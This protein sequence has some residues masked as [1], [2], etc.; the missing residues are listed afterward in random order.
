MK[1]IRFEKVTLL[2]FCGID[3][4]EIE[5]YHN[6]TTICGRNGIGKSTIFNAIYYVLFG[7]DQFGNALDIKT[8]DYNHQIIREIPHEASLTISV[9][10]EETTFKRTLTDLWK[11]EQVKNTYKYFID[12][13]VVTAGDYR[14]AIENI[15]PEKTF[16]LCSSATAFTSMSWQEQRKFLQS[17]VPE[18]TQDDITQGD[19]KYDFITEELKKR[20]LDAF[21]HHLKYTRKEVQD[22]LDKVPVR[23]AELNNALP[24]AEDWE[25]LAAELDEAKKGLKEVS[26]KI[27]L[28]QNGA[29]DSVRNEGLRRRIE[30][31]QKRIDEMTTSARNLSNEEATKHESDL[32]SARAAASTATRMVDELKQKM[33]GLTNTEIQ[34]NKHKE[35][36]EAEVS[37]LNERSASISQMKWEWNDN[38][39][40]CP[41]CGQPLPL[42]RVS[43]LK[44]QSHDRFNNDISDRQKEL[45]KEF[46]DLQQRYTD[47]KKLIENTN[48]ERRNTTNQLTEAQKAKKQADAHLEAIL[49]E[50]V[51]TAD[52]FLAANDNYRQATEE[53]KSLTEELNKPSDSTKDISQL[54]I[55]LKNQQTEKQQTVDSFSSRLAAKETYDHIYTLISNAQ[56][57][58]AKYQEQLDNIDQKLDTAND[59]QQ[60]ACQLL[61]ERVNKHFSYVQFSLFK[62]T[63]EGERKQAC[64]CYHDGVP[65]SSLNTAAK[66]NAGIDIA[67]TVAEKFG[68]SVPIIL[69][70]CESNLSPIYRGGQ[71]I[72]LCVTPSTNFEYVFS[73]GD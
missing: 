5:F 64:E 25:K 8:Y 51:R 18:V 59:Y 17:L 4:A 23:L 52:D 28:A 33:E 42:D 55:D 26:D 54:L 39:S 24:Q 21:I 9:D 22:N 40:I 65:Y 3:N 71:Q 14:K 43:E 37:N 31:T 61:E 1:T 69:D 11:G 34:A 56:G 7:T 73:D 53:L 62:S 63:L 50:N 36:C 72:R 35:E 10:G 60:K 29:T 70:E 41:H 49:A 32:I 19:T 67:Y 2:N 6:V 38:D 12:G 45:Q 48:E 66:V 47:I 58:K 27:N 46:S 30:F 68:L 15:C 20:E 16:R 13:E 57:D 44:Q